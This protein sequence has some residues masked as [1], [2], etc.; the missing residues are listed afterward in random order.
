[1]SFMILGISE[2]VGS[3]LTPEKRAPFQRAISL[4]HRP[5]PPHPRARTPSDRLRELT[6]VF[7]AVNAELIY[8]LTSLN[9]AAERVCFHSSFGRSP[10]GPPMASVQ[11]GN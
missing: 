9:S 11:S 7:M 2:K 3:F 8:P 5:A 6:S 1:M 10:G 4:Y